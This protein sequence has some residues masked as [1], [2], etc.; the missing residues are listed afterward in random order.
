MQTTWQEEAAARQR[1]MAE[2]A[3]AGER[4]YRQNVEIFT[5]M[6]LTLGSD[7][8][9]VADGSRHDQALAEAKSLAASRWNQ[10]LSI[11]Q[12]IVREEQILATR[13]KKRPPAHDE[14]LLPDRTVAQ[15]DAAYLDE[16]KHRQAA[17]ADLKEQAKRERRELESFITT[18]RR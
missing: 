18:K 1:A 14:E 7:V 4:A 5:R 13:G 11:E 12:Q 6:W 2:E 15:R 17:L 3:A 16:T 10:L 9:K 8:I